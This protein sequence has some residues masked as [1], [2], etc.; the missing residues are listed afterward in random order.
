MAFQNKKFIV[1][2]KSPEWFKEQCSLG[3]AKVVYDDEGDFVNIIV[4][5]ATKNYTA[6]KGDVIMLLKSGL[7]V[8]PK[9]QAVKYKIQKE[10]K[11]EVKDE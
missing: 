3:R 4:Y 9:E 6:K 10:T 11:E 2:E 5:S 7:A 8:I 1:G